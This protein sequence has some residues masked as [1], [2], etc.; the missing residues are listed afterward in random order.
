MRV[1]VCAADLLAAP[2]AHAA[3]S[4][5][6]Q[7]VARLPGPAPATPTPAFD[8]VDRGKL[9]AG[10]KVLSAAKAANGRVWVVTDKGAFVAEAGGYVPLKFGPQKLEPGQP[11]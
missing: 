6:P 7:L 10:A 11:G 5:Y 1:L 3:E 8:F 4:T 9:P 2:V